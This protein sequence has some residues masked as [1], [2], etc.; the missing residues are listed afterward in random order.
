MAEKDMTLEEA[1]KI[2]SNEQSRRNH[3]KEEQ[4]GLFSVYENAIKQA[5]QEGRTRIGLDGRE[6]KI[7]RKR[8][9]VI[10]K[11]AE[12]FVPVWVMDE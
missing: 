10:I 4:R 3:Q 7:V 2:L 6:F 5:V 1:S 9:R 11:P 12:G 8:G